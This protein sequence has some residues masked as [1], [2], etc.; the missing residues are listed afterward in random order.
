MNTNLNLDNLKK[1]HQELTAA[2]DVAK[3]EANKAFESRKISDQEFLQ[4]KDEWGK[5][6]VQESK[7]RGLIMAKELDFILNINEEDS[8]SSRILQATNRLRS[9]ARDLD[10]FG[11]F[12]SAIADVIKIAGSVIT[13]IQ[14]G[15]ILTFPA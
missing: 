4:A 10:N 6:E 2:I 11:S 12:L 14:T 1:I 13:A 8:P 15:G 3:T 9:S 5:L 7:L